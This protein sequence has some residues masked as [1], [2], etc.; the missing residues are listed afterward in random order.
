MFRFCRVFFA[1]ALCCLM[2]GAF[3]AWAAADEPGAL[4]KGWGNSGARFKP[5]NPIGKSAAEIAPTVGMASPPN[6]TMGCK[7]STIPSYRKRL[8]LS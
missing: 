5:W 7:S 1:V 3:P 2:T 8:T 4:R 6:P